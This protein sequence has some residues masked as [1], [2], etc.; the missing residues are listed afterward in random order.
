MSQITK[1]IAL[2]ET[3]QDVVS[4]IQGITQGGMIV[5]T[6]NVGSATQPVYINGGVPTA[7]SGALGVAN[8]G[9][10]NTI[11]KGES[12]NVNRIANDG[13]VNVDTYTTDTKATTHF[14]IAPGSASNVPADIWAVYQTMSGSGTGGDYAAQ[15]AY[16]VTHDQIWFRRKKTGTWQPWHQIYGITTGTPTNINSN[17]SMRATS[18]VQKSGNVVNFRLLFDVSTAFTPG[19]TT[20][21][22]EMPYTAAGGQYF[23]VERGVGPFANATLGHCFL[24][25]KNLEFGTGPYPALASSTLIWVSGTYLTND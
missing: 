1:P 15:V 16:S 18:L 10:G 12:I 25:N 14:D 24:R 4:A 13:D 7:M 19:E 20:K 17:L 22:C 11:G 3:L 8:G 23:Y 5:S 2:D 9:T 21:L 6:G